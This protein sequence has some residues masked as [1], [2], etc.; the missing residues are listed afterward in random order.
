MSDSNQFNQFIATH[1]LSLTDGVFYFKLLGARNGYEVI[2]DT[3]T[4]P[5][6]LFTN[7]TKPEIIHNK[8]TEAKNKLFGNFRDKFNEVDR[9]FFLR[10]YRN[11]ETYKLL[12]QRTPTEV[13][14]GVVAVVD[15]TP[16]FSEYPLWNFKNEPILSLILRVRSVFTFFSHRD[17]FKEMLLGIT[18]GDEGTKTDFLRYIQDSEGQ[19]PLLP[20]AFRHTRDMIASD[21]SPK[22]TT[23]LP[24]QPFTIM[25]QDCDIMLTDTT[26]LTA[27][28]D[29]EIQPDYALIHRTGT[30]NVMPLTHAGYRVHNWI[31]TRGNFFELCDSGEARVIMIAPDTRAQKIMAFEPS[32][33]MH[34]MF[35]LYS[36]MSPLKLSANTPTD[37]TYRMEGSYVAPARKIVSSIPF[38]DPMSCTS[39]EIEELKPADY[40]LIAQYKLDGNRIL[41]Y[42]LDEGASIKYYT[43]NGI[44]QS[45]KFN[46]Q[47]DK[48]VKELF[49]RIKA[50]KQVINIMLD[51][52]CYCHDVVHSDI[53]G[54][55]N[56]IE[57]TDNFRKLKLYLLSWLNL[58]ALQEI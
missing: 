4:H 56:K 34:S 11:P 16:V 40:P 10:L 31:D 48:A 6:S 9:P 17:E 20:L 21:I 43:R 30:K 15:N 39:K 41:I 49:L 5:L 37:I 2:W 19:G 27:I 45:A 38:R 51:C 54:W 46:Q 50:Q 58:D 52:E 32:M 53:G 47:F 1:N 18:I 33:L 44:L 25:E 28:D 55:C 14:P 13:R 57:I 42:V 7:S 35:L 23:E 36:R 12:T 29:Y 3:R 24:F 26:F 8:Q 22:I